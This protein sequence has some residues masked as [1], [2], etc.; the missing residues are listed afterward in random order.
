MPQTGY[1]LSCSYCRSRSHISMH[2]AHRTHWVRRKNQRVLVDRTCVPFRS[3]IV[4][5]AYLSTADRLWI[6]RVPP[7][8]PRNRTLK[9]KRPSAPPKK[10]VRKAS[11]SVPVI[12]RTDDPVGRPKREIHPPP[13]KD[14]PYTDAPK[15]RKTKIPK[16]GEADRLKFCDKILKDLNKKT[17]YTVAHPFYEPVGMWFAHDVLTKSL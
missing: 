10:P 15:K 6:Q 5:V 2:A 17:H 3:C 16:S 8:P 12:R 4:L 7:K 11:T 1:V 14:L 9:R 13:P